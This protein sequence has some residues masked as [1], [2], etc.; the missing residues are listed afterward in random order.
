MTPF[1]FAIIIAYLAENEAYT[2]GGSLMGSTIAGL[3]V[4]SICFVFYTFNT[5]KP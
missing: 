4:G 1:Q 3:L 5:K 2:R